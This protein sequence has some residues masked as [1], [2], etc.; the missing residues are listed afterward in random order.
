M[1]GGPE[2]IV[3]VIADKPVEFSYE[4]VLIAGKMEVLENDV[5]YYRLT[6]ASQARE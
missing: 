1:P 6:G 3:E 5:V 4:P 2:S